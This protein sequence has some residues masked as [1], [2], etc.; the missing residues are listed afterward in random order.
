MQTQ[1]P[2]K[3]VLKRHL[4]S[5][6]WHFCFGLFDKKKMSLPKRPKKH[7]MAVLCGDVKATFGA[8]LV[9]AEVRQGETIYFDL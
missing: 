3:P 8:D 4:P 1:A 7:S 9:R 6:P 2:P 5:G